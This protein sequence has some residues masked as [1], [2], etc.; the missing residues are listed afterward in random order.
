MKFTQWHLTGGW[1]G[2]NSPAVSLAGVLGQ[3]RLELWIRV[4]SR[5]VSSMKALEYR[6]LTGG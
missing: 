4:S 5:G 2:Q 3:A 1:A 6:P